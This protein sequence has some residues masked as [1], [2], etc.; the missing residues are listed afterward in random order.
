MIMGSPQLERRRVARTAPTRKCSSAIVFGVALLVSCT[1]NPFPDDGRVPA[2]TTVELQRGVCYGKCPVY[3]LTVKADGTVNFIGGEFTE[4]LGEAE[5]RIS[6]DQ[7]RALIRE[8]ENADYFALNGDYTTEDC[9]TDHPTVWTALTINGETKGIQ[10]N[11]GCDSPAQLSV[12]EDRID[13]IVGSQIW[14]GDGR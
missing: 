12:L 5:G 6:E 3:T 1:P 9:A 11:S 4:T 10:H 8:F 14:V 7:V 2:D 13:E